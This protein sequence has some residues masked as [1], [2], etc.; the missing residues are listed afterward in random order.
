MKEKLKSFFAAVGY[1]FLTFGI[2][3]I[4]SIVGGG[5]IGV[6]YA[7]NNLNELNG[8]NPEELT[9]KIL[10]L[11]NY[12]LL[13]SS[14]ITVLVFLLIYKIR[15]KNFKE[16]LQIVKTAKVNLIIGITLGISAWLFNSGALSLVQESGLFKDN[17]S[18]MENL[19][20]PLNQGNIFIALLT[21]GII[22]PFTEEFM[23]RGVIFKTLNKNISILWTIIIQAL[24]FGIFHGNLIQGTYATLLG[25]VFGYITY[26]T[27]S[28]WT[29][30]I[31]HMINNSIATLSPYILKNVPD[32]TSILIGFVVV[33]AIGLITSLYFIKK[34]N[35]SYEDV[36]I[37]F[38]DYRD[39]N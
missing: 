29:S 10:G 5:I 15:K 13:A 4:V 31:M 28:L 24:F 3:L 26:K 1:L 20:A 38:N 7:M 27:K 36:T 18:M 33:G 21:V 19:L 14:I 37:N 25:L 16:E 17:F 23:F 12:I 8:F 22:A 32:L 39:L 9:N 2:Q 11:T 34:K 6:I 30:I 35:I